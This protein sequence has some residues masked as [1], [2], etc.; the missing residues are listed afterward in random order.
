MNDLGVLLV[1]RIPG[2]I[3]MRLKRPPRHQNDFISKIKHHDGIIFV[4]YTP[5][6][7][8]L[9]VHYN[10]SVISSA[11]I[12]VRV[13]IALSLEYDNAKVNLARIETG[14]KLT[15]GD[16][17]AAGS[18]AAAITSKGFN[19]TGS[20]LN[21]LE[22]NAGASTLLAVLRHAWKEVKKDG[23]YDPEVIS[24]VY[25]I[26]AM[27][28]GNFITASVITWIATFGR[29][30]LSPAQENCSLEAIEFIDENEKPY[31]DVIIRN[32]TSKQL[33]KNILKLMVIGFGK[34]V[35]L[36][37]NKNRISIFEQ[38]QEMSRKH[39]N[40]LE[41]VGNINTPVYMRLNS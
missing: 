18:L 10:P 16:Y 11:E 12:M 27:L 2:R 25:L 41:G 6:T 32:S 9:L 29:H 39:S 33:D 40:V 31:V 1:H 37:Y 26:N 7:K 20:T 19:F 8:S 22:F 36:N 5:I 34:T 17:Y 28:K 24:V 14:Q 13:G 3:R 38:V 35:G 23:I 21:L 30:I 4:K 15:L